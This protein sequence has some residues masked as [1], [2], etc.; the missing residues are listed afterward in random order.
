MA[1]PGRLAKQNGQTRCVVSTFAHAV[2]H[3]LKADRANADVAAM[4]H[5]IGIRLTISW[6]CDMV[7]SPVVRHSG[8]S[9]F[10]RS[11]IAV[12]NS[13]RLVIIIIIIIITIIII[14]R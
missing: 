14:K 2:G 12:R 1:R 10:C 13:E 11:S 6:Q 9:V 5:S 8:R 4:L 3:G 7:V